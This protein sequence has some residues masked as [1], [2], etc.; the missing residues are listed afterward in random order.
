[1]QILIDPSQKE[2]KQHGDFEFP[3][4][5]SYERLSRYE[6]GS[7]LWH[8]HPEIELTLIT[9]GQILYQVHEQKYILKKGQALFCNANVL[10]AGTMLDESDCEYCSV[11]FDPR[12][13]YG[14]TNSL[15]ARKYVEPFLNDLSLASIPLDLSK[16]WHKE[17]I[18]LLEHI[19]CTREENSPLSPFHIQ[20]ALQQFWCLL[21]EHVKPGA[22]LSAR[23]R[24]DYERIRSILILIEQ[25]YMEKLSL[26]DIAENIHMC[27]GECCRLFKRYMNVTLFEF[28]LQ[29]RIEKSLPYLL[30]G[31]YSIT[32][33]AG[34]TGF[35]DSNYY[36]K[37]FRKIKG[38]TPTQYR[39]YGK[40]DAN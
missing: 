14:F 36:T 19:I 20:I 34:F 40:A 31:R 35:C 3:F 39:K 2:I 7:F 27:E 29:Y 23:K 8:W 10:H 18:L 33:V 15:I 38:C 32:E 21:C 28:L 24:R 17:A 11:T 25:K 13:I 12:L 30:S 16:D 26:A 9:G 5:L 22:P 1:M 6:T 37:V 4:L